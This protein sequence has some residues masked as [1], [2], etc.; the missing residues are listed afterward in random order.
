MPADSRNSICV[1]VRSTVYNSVFVL[2]AISREVRLVS[3]R[4]AFVC[5]LLQVSRRLLPQWPHWIPSTL[6]L[7]PLA[8][9]GIQHSLTGSVLNCLLGVFGA[10]NA[11]SL[12][13]WCDWRG[14]LGLFRLALNKTICI[15]FT[16]DLI[17]H[18]IFCK[19]RENI[20]LRGEGRLRNN[21]PAVYTLARFIQISHP[22]MKSVFIT[23]NQLMR[24]AGSV[25]TGLPLFLCIIQPKRATWWLTRHLWNCRSSFCFY[26]DHFALVGVPV[27]RCQ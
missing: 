8:T 12:H 24:A 22:Q 18:E 27:V 10:C 15:P 2:L 4:S 7:L 9:Q 13:N 20:D 23:R 11:D 6:L 1:Y 14:S 5:G 17:S 26:T 25:L 16:P 3:S 21:Q 19:L